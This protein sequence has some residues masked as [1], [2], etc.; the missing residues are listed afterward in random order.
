MALLKRPLTKET[1]TIVETNNNNSN[2]SSGNNKVDTEYETAVK[3]KKRCS[4]DDDANNNITSMTASNIKQEDKFSHLPQKKRS[5]DFGKSNTNEDQDDETL[6]RETQAALKSLSGSWP[7]ARNNPYRLTEQ[8]E[9]PPPFQNLF[10][11]KQKYEQYS[12]LTQDETS[13]YSSLDL[14]RFHRQKENDQARLN[15]QDEAPAYEDRKKS[16]FSQASAFKPPLDV[17]R[18]GVIGYN[19][20][21]NSSHYAT[22]YGTVD[23]STGYLS[24]PP[25]PPLPSLPAVSS[26]HS[27]LP[28]THSHTANSLLA[29]RSPYE[30]GL[31]AETLK[32]ESDS[33]SLKAPEDDKHYTTLQ[34]AGVGSRAAS[35]MQDINR[36][37]SSSVSIS[38]ADSQVSSTANLIPQP[39]YSP[40]S[41]NRGK[42]CP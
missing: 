37:T 27:S 8:D 3:R 29:T 5:L 30:D 6:I 2:G 24:Y 18:N 10:E 14:L 42:C 40:G 36:E 17:K 28:N 33:S 13:T 41:L 25:P 35:V 4:R 16:A 26:T 11:E 1:T 38:A 23:S 32:T 15:S 39:T 34:P 21:V 22:S 31:K 7:E 20:H 12:K 9:N 19:S